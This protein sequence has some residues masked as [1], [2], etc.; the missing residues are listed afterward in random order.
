MRVA[1]WNIL[2]GMSLQ[3]PEAAS[4]LIGQAALL[5]A[6]II[7]LQEVDHNQTRTG[8]Q[9]QT[10]DVAEAMGL[11][12]W[13]FAPAIVGTPGESWV[14]AG[15]E[16]TSSHQHAEVSST[17]DPASFYGVGLASRWPMSNI[18]VVRFK[19]APISLPLLVPSM[20]RPRLIKVAD[21]PRVAIVADIAT[22]SG[23]VT[24][25]TTHLSFVPGFNIKQLRQLVKNMPATRSLILGDFNLPGGL[26]TRITKW[27]SLAKIQTYPTF[28]PK[29]QFD[30]ILA[31]GYSQEV[32]EYAR[33][34]AQ[35]ES[36]SVSDHCALSVEILD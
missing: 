36:L 12:F 13:Y 29:V 10:R 22:P 32:V 11:P 15:D 18:R 14:G 19:A 21:E 3:N 26:P 16:H 23:L 9:H 30:H 2:H 34:S 5:N 17:D 28:G 1:T 20:P 31:Q 35:S 4:E 24:V 27:S 25:A 8:H 6:D 7:G 33:A